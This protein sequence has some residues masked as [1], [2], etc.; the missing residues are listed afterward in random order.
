MTEDK[1]SHKKREGG[2]KRKKEGTVKADIPV[3]K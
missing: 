1:N 3:S 2:E